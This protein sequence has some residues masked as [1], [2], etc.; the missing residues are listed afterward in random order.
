MKAV[1]Y[2]LGVMLLMIYPK[3]EFKISKN[4][5]P[6]IK[7]SFKN[8]PFKGTHIFKPAKGDYLSQINLGFHDKVSQI[9]ANKIISEEGIQ[10]HNF[11]RSFLGEAKV[12]NQTT[13][14]YTSGC[15]H[16]NFID[17]KNNQK[18][19]RIDGDFTGCTKTKI[20]KVTP[21]KKSVVK[22]RRK[23]TGTF[24]D[25]IKFKITNDDG[26]EETIITEVT[27]E[28]LANQSKF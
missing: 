18:Y 4:L 3:E 17:F 21:W 16:L 5:K 28:F 1:L 24:T 19:K 20:T 2:V 7:I 25:S 11:S 23:V 12:G 9:S 22:F 14:K 15:G 27:I 10:I 26:S 6:Y 13:K 8:G